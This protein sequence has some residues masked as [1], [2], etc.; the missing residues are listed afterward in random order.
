MVHRLFR[1]VSKFEILVKTFW[2]CLNFAK[3]A[4]PKNLKQNDKI[5]DRIAAGPLHEICLL[6]DYDIRDLDK[7]S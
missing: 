1:L 3:I 2:A 4:Y 6:N 7:L 5:R